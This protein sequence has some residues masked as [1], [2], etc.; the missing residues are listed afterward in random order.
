MLLIQ[1]P[2]HGQKRTLMTDGAWRIKCKGQARLGKLR[3]EIWKKLGCISGYMRP[4]H[5]ISDTLGRSTPIHCAPMLWKCTCTSFHS[6]LPTERITMMLQMLQLTHC[7]TSGNKQQFSLRQTQGLVQTTVHWP[8]LPEVVVAGCA[9]MQGNPNVCHSHGIQLAKKMKKRGPGIRYDK[10]MQ[11]VRTAQ[12]HR[13]TILIQHLPW[14]TMPQSQGQVKQVND[15]TKK[16]TN[17]SLRLQRPAAK[18]GCR[19]ATECRGSKSVSV[20]SPCWSSAWSLVSLASSSSLSSSPSASSAWWSN[21]CRYA[22]GT[23]S[24]SCS[25]KT[26]EMPSDFF[27]TVTEL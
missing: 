25:L 3:K 18:Q 15:Q 27:T 26:A 17:K 20:S 12:R 19:L 13:D 14:Q 9:T 6:R 21:A 11:V 1:L 2:W 22:E 10:I 7:K 5:E 24:S 4:R 8:M 16:S 23:C